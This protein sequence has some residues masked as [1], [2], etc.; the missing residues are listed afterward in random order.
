MED[1][2]P[3]WNKWIGKEVIKRSKKPFKSGKQIETVV[4]LTINPHSNKQA[5]RLN[6]TSIV[7][8]YQLR[9]HSDDCPKCTQTKSNCECHIPDEIKHKGLHDFCKILLSDEGKK[10]LRDVTET[11]KEK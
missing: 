2:K 11:K 6:D 9:L 5:F 3:N 8:C 1:I 7:D 4:E 10:I